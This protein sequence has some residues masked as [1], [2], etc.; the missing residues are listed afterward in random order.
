MDLGQSYIIPEEKSEAKLPNS[1][2]MTPAIAKHFSQASLLQTP[3][4]LSKPNPVASIQHPQFPFSYSK[5]K[6]RPKMIE[7]IVPDNNDEVVHL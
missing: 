7:S 4:P 6:P 3:A 2:M 5:P 1:N